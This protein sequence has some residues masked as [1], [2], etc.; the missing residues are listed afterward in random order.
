[1]SLLT[2]HGSTLLRVIAA[3]API[4]DQERDMI[5]PTRFEELG[6]LCFTQL[7]ELRHRGAFS[8]VAQT[9]AT[10]CRRCYSV[11]DEHLR[12]LPEKWYKVILHNPLSAT[13]CIDIQGNTFEHPSSSA[14]HHTTFWRH[15]RTHGR[16]YSCRTA[17]EWQVVRASYARPHRRGI[18]R[19]RELEH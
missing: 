17:I 3:R 10:F 19:G 6:R 9:F 12:G 11:D 14:R 13:C 1:M 7:I 18:G 8:A 16:H 4:G 15:P 2:D 5:T